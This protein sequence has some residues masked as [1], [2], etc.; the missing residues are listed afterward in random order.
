MVHD[1][2]ANI[3]LSVERHRPATIIARSFLIH[4]CDWAAVK[5][6]LTSAPWQVISTFDEIEDMWYFFKITLYNILNECT[7]LK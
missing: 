5:K 4:K 2:F 3:D 6:S 1:Q 7:P